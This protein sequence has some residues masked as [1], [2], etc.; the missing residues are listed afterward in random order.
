MLQDAIMNHGY[1]KLYAYLVTRCSWWEN[2]KDHVEYMF[3]GMVMNG[4]ENIM[5]TFQLNEFVNGTDTTAGSYKIKFKRSK[6]DYSGNLY[7]FSF[8]A[9][10]SGNYTMISKWPA[11]YNL[12]TTAR[13]AGLFRSDK[14][15]VL[16]NTA[17]LS[18]WQGR[19]MSH[20]D[21]IYNAEHI[22]A[23]FRCYCVKTLHYIFTTNH[24]RASILGQLRYI[25]YLPLNSYDDD[26]RIV[27]MLDILTTP[28]AGV[29]SL[30]TVVHPTLIDTLA[31]DGNLIV[32]EWFIKKY[33]SGEFKKVLLKPNRYYAPDTIGT[34][35][36]KL[37]YTLKWYKNYFLLLSDNIQIQ[38]VKLWMGEFRTT[39]ENQVTTL[40][41]FMDHCRDHKWFI[42]H[43]KMMTTWFIG[44]SY[45]MTLVKSR[46]FLPAV[47]NN[48]YALLTYVVE[49]RLFAA[50]PNDL[51]TSDLH[52]YIANGA[53]VPQEILNVYAILYNEGIITEPVLNNS[54]YD[55]MMNDAMNMLYQ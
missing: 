23:L 34:W 25:E 51:F 35:S 44:E 15:D 33:G 55:S 37:R 42:D 43:L 36:P 53:N 6:S 47:I 5:E 29:G 39:Y 7:N 27:Q 46:I 9:G 30:S 22:A 4:H 13:D 52:I 48:W 20:Y 12:D 41:P 3:L 14:I 1:D 31:L 16:K 28:I 17:Y 2:E 21:R 38:C 24:G 18:P 50:F 49:R 10:Y 54:D 19:D 32:T 26:P 11:L 45:T 8:A 40:I